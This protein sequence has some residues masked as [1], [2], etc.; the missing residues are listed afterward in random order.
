MRD[1]V[2]ATVGRLPWHVSVGVRRNRGPSLTA[3]EGHRGGGSIVGRRWVLTAA[4]CLVEISDLLPSHGEFVLPADMCVR[5][6]TG[7]DLDVPLEEIDVIR[8]KRHPSYDCRSLEYDAALLE[9]SREVRGAT[10]LSVRDVMTGDCG[11]IAGWGHPD[12]ESEIVP[13]L[14]WARVHV[15]SDDTCVRQRWGSVA[16]NPGLMFAAGGAEDACPSFP[17]ASVRKGDSGSGFVVTRAGYQ[18][19]CGIA[20]WSAAV[21]RG[22]D[23]PQVF[24]RTFAIADWIARETHC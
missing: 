16:G 13:H 20:S 9:L 18:Y 10:A 7:I 3:L 1:G 17:R 5:V 24:T 15:G 8:V 12:L 22:I 2:P 6:V 14:D 19:L 11:V 21:P 4:H 23:G